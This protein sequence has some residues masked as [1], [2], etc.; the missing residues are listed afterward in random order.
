MHGYN[1]INIDDEVTVRSEVARLTRLYD[2]AVRTNTVNNPDMYMAGA[3]DGANLGLKPRTT[4][5]M[6]PVVLPDPAAPNPTVPGPI[7]A[8]PPLAPIEDPD[9]SP[10]TA[11]PK[12]QP[13]EEPPKEP[14]TKDNKKPSI[15]ESSKGKAPE[16]A[17]D[18]ASEPSADT[19]PLEPASEGNGAK[20]P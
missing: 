6:A 14:A 5:P 7:V 8:E 1:D 4:Q 9:E 17:K 15:I 13:K 19:E 12:P 18:A 11:P 3:N 2:R 16:G 20:S 10:A